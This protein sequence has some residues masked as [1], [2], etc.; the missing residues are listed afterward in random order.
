MKLDILLRLD[1]RDRDSQ[2]VPIRTLG[3]WDGG[4][5]SCLGVILD[6]SPR[7]E[8]LVTCALHNNL[9]FF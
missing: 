2:N 7:L 1:T 8:S 9:N 5:V 3:Y 4:M 6:V